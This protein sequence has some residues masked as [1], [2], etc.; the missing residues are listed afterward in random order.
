MTKTEILLVEDNPQDAELTL[1][2]F[3]KQ[4]LG[5]KIHLAKDGEEALE[6]INTNDVSSHLKVVF[7]DLKLPK[8]NGIEFLERIRNQQKTKNVP[9]VIVTSSQEPRDLMQCY[10]LGANSYVVKPVDYENFMSIF[11]ELGTYWLQI[12]KTVNAN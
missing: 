3:A 12:N 10:V 4:N 1:R 9:V 11:S 7:L 5:D 6:F 2:A 8:I